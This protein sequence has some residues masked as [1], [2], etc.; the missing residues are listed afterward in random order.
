EASL[1][2]IPQHIKVVYVG[3]DISVEVIQRLGARD[4][5]MFDF[6]ATQSQILAAPAA[7]KRILITERMRAELPSDTRYAFYKGD[8]EELIMRDF[9]LEPEREKIARLQREPVATPSVATTSQR[10]KA[11]FDPDPARVAGKRRRGDDH[12]VATTYPSGLSLGRR[13]AASQ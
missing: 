5:I 10:E 6:E 13:G 3:D 12:S 4:I 1:K 11:F 2:E 9:G 8:G 7:A